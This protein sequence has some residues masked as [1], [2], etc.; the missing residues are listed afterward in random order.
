MADCVRKH[1][2]LWRRWA[3]GWMAAMLCR[4]AS[5]PA[6]APIAKL[7]GAAGPLGE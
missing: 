1:A 5:A 2:N 6:S 7:G 3:K 4:A